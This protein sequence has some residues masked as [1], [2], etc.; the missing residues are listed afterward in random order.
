M[1]RLSNGLPSQAGSVNRPSAFAGASADRPAAIA[2]SSLPS[3]ATR[4]ATVRGRRARLRANRGHDTFGAIRSATPNTGLVNSRSSGTANSSKLSVSVAAI[5]LPLLG[6]ARFDRAGEL[7]AGRDPQPEPWS[8]TMFT[9]IDADMDM[10]AC[11]YV[12]G[13]LLRNRR[14]PLTASS[15]LSL[16]APSSYRRPTNSGRRCAGAQFVSTHSD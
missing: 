2:P 14:W 8:R 16:R 5:L 9:V 11:R 12:H 15:S 6:H 4:E 10:T 13:T 1:V 3:V 7:N